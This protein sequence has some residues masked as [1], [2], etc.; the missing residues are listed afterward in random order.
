MLNDEIRTGL[1]TLFVEK[2]IEN[3]EYEYCNRSKTEAAAELSD[4]YAIGFLER[5]RGSSLK[6]SDLPSHILLRMYKNQK[7]LS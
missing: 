6:D 5:I 2:V 3:R 4:S 1:G 7:H